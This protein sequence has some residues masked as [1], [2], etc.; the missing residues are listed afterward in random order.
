MLTYYSFIGAAAIIFRKEASG[1]VL[2]WGKASGQGPS[3]GKATPGWISRSLVSVHCFHVS[4]VVP[5]SWQSTHRT[6]SPSLGMSCCPNCLLAMG[7]EVTCH[8]S[9]LGCVNCTLL[10]NETHSH[11]APLKTCIYSTMPVLLTDLSGLWK[12]LVHLVQNLENLQDHNLFKSALCTLKRLTSYNVKPNH[13][14]LQEVNIC[15][16]Q[17]PWQGLSC[18]VLSGFPQAALIHR[19][20]WPQASVQDGTRCVSPPRGIAM[21]GQCRLG[22]LGL[23]HNMHVTFNITRI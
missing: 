1:C 5:E 12:Y 7:V 3:P 18:R 14:P 8:V 19:N 17:L 21:S 15:V 9:L 2:F 16:G 13:I 23:F 11:C 6:E 10:L 22:Q 20:P 4:S